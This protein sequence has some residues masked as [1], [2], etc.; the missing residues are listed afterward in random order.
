[1]KRL[2][3]IDE[4]V[5]ADIHKRS[6]GQKIKL[7][8]AF[9]PDYIDFGPETT[10]YW[11]VNNLEIDGEGKFSFEDV[12]DYNNN[13]W[14]LPTPE[15]VKQVNWSNIRTPWYDHC[16]HLLFPD[17]NELKLK[18]ES[19]NGF[20]M[21]TSDYDPKFP[22]CAQSYGFDN[23]SKF[24]T[25]S[26]NIHWN[27]LYVF[28]V[29]DKKKV[30]ESVWSDIHKRSNGDQ[31]RK[32]DEFS[33]LKYL[34]P[35]DMGGS[36]L[37][38]NN[39]IE[40]KDGDSYFT[41]DEAF[42]LVKNSGWRLPTLEEVAELDV[43]YNR[44]S[45]SSDSEAFYF[46]HNSNVLVFEKKGFIYLTASDKPIDID[47]YYCWTSTLLKSNNR[48]AHILTFDNDHPIHTPLNYTNIN[49]TVAQDITNGKLCIRLVKDK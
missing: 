5:W 10:V 34:K 31:I 23:M 32:E 30:N 11:A 14:R 7:E 37:W 27:K 17:G 4:S 26:F 49:D 41:F 12:K 21:W 44:G 48:F 45:Y 38:A 6:T 8:D 46:K 22:T 9:H 42:E 33:N 2:S 19:N 40:L 43:L 25:D 1:M 16:T 47:F 36:V 18:R 28:L 15:E 29:K 3:K 13:G 24:N 35:L 20:H 39:D